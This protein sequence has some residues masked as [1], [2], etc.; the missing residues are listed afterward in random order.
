MNVESA[1]EGKKDNHPALRAPLQ[2]RGIRKHERYVGSSF[3]SY[4][5]FEKFLI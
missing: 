2:R 4:F 1:R 5:L 3:F